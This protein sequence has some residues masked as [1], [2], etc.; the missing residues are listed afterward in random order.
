MALG[1]PGQV[2]M[3]SS[4]EKN[5]EE[6][7]G[8]CAAECQLDQ[9]H[10]RLKNFGGLA[11]RGELHLALPISPVQVFEEKHLNSL[12]HEMRTL[13]SCARIRYCM[14]N[15]GHGGKN[16]SILGQEMLEEL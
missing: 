11:P 10:A 1:T 8:L 15:F 4:K 3:T 6:E 5:G 9:I 14:D 13:N 7:G 12:S 16:R 2:K